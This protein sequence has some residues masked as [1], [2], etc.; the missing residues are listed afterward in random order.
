MAAVVLGWR[1]VGLVRVL[2]YLPKVLRSIGTSEAAHRPRQVAVE[3]AFL[4][5]NFLGQLV[6]QNPGEDGVL[7]EVLVAAARQPV[8]GHELLEIRDLVVLPS[9]NQIGLLYDFFGVERGDLCEVE[10]ARG[11]QAD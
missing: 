3:L 6:L 1:R 2:K 11:P 5:V 8:E 10:G 4:Q 9:F 7:G